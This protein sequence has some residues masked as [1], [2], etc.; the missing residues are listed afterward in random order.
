VKPDQF[1]V[2]HELWTD[3]F[4]WLSLED[5]V[6]A[7]LLANEIG[8]YPHRTPN[9]PPGERF[10]LRPASG[11]PSF[12]PSDFRE[13]V[14]RFICSRVA[15]AKVTPCLRKAASQIAELVNECNQRTYV[16]STNWDTL[17]EDALKEQVPSLDLATQRAHG[18]GHATFE[19]R[20]AKVHGSL[21]IKRH[22]QT[23]ALQPASA[24]EWDDESTWK[25]HVPMI[26][27]PGIGKRTSLAEAAFPYMYEAWTWAG[28]AFGASGALISAGFSWDPNDRDLLFLARYYSNGPDTVRSFHADDERVASRLSAALYGK[29]DYA[30]RVT[31]GGTLDQLVSKGLHEEAMIALT[32]SHSRSLHLDPKAR[33]WMRRSAGPS[34]EWIEEYDRIEAEMDRAERMAP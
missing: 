24:E 25:D 3:W 31:S 15:E 7:A 28:H 6:D 29:P 30:D 11:G 20:I 22:R 2:L 4:P 33:K 5:M 32:R 12:N 17:L 10:D 1:P 26:G 14:L 21:G 19:V 18:A 16:I 23:G 27:L 13:E 8:V 34:R 9:P